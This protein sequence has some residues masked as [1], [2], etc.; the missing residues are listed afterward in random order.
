[1]RSRGGR[2]MNTQ[3]ARA[4][5]ARLLEFARRK[6]RLAGM[7]VLALMYPS[8][9]LAR[10]VDPL[11]LSRRFRSAEGRTP[12]RTELVALARERCARDR[13]TADRRPAAASGEEEDE[14]W[15][16]AAPILL[17]QSHAPEADHRTG[18]TSGRPRLVGWRA[19]NRRV[20]IRFRRPRRTSAGAGQRRR[21]NSGSPPADLDGGPSRY[22]ARGAGGLCAART[23]ARWRRGSRVRE[24]GSL[25]RRGP[26]RS[27]SVAF[28]TPRRSAPL[29]RGTRSR[30]HTGS[31]CLS[32]PSTAAFRLCSTNTRTCSSR[33]WA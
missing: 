29:V 5:R 23:A 10:E 33:R 25:P 22:G 19:S 17:D 2:P 15:Y 32:T 9:T 31:E 16:W 8:P 18:S 14:A 11:L 4:K 7:P 3:E 27:H 24:S 28:S 6:G 1:M 30:S 12:T 21:W 20:I 13:Q 26:P